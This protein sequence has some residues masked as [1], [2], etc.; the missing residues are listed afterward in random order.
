ME[1]DTLTL[2]EAYDIANGLK[3]VSRAREDL[4]WMLVAA[5]LDRSLT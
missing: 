2:D 4:A 1:A 3:V 5:D